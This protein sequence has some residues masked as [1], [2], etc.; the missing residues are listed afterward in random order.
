MP[1][2]GGVILGPIFDKIFK[3]RDARER[4]DRERQAKIREILHEPEVGDQSDQQVGDK[5]QPA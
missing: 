1:G 3:G 5:G 4:L 2:L